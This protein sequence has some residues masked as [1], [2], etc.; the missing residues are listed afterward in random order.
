MDKLTPMTSWTSHDGADQTNPI[1]FDADDFSS[2]RQPEL[3]TPFS[4][5]SRHHSAPGETSPLVRKRAAESLIFCSRRMARSVR[6]RLG[7]LAPHAA[8]AQRTASLP[9]T[10][11][12]WLIGLVTLVVMV[13][14]AALMFAGYVLGFS[15]VLKLVKWAWTF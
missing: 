10:I 15:A 13:V 7:M 12:D 4:P 6:Q 8:T 1:P 11:G 3:A 9:A 2:N 5:P 14:C